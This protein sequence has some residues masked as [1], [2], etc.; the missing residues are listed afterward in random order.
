VANQIEGGII[1][2]FVSP[3][4]GEEEVEIGSRPSSEYPEIPVPESTTLQ[5]GQVIRIM[6]ELCKRQMYADPIVVR[7]RPAKIGAPT[8][9]APLYACSV[10]VAEDDIVPGATVHVFQEGI[11][12]GYAWSPGNSVVVYPV[13]SLRENARVTAYQVVGGQRS[14]DSDPIIVNALKEH[15]P[16]PS[17]PSPIRPGDM[18]VWVTGLIPGAYVRLFDNG[19]QVGSGHSADSSASIPIWWPIAE[20]AIITAIQSLCLIKSEESAPR[21]ATSEATC[22]G[23]PPYEPFLWNT[24]P[25]VQWHNNCYNYAC[26]IILFNDKSQPGRASGYSPSMSCTDVTTAA[27]LDGLQPCPAACR[28]CHPC[29]HKVALVMAPGIDYHWYRQDDTGLWSHKPGRNQ[30]RNVDSSGNLITNP[31]AADRR[32]L[33]EDGSVA[34]VYSEFCGYFCVNKNV[35]VIL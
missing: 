28:A 19:V 32:A 15:L 34:F 31:E 18:S 9:R 2:L 5:A 25:K 1:T 11:P 21:P 8:V 23:P 3:Y 30:A 14:S 7:P 26:N 13:T 22:Y 16:R 17:V 33:K 12:I 6:Q 27:T 24:D 29:H 10:I 20:D 35:V 4:Q